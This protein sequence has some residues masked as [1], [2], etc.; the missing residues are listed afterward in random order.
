MLEKSIEGCWNVDG[1]RG[2]SD[3]W[4]GFARFTILD[5]KKPPDWMY[6]VRGATDKEVNDIQ[7]RLRVARDTERH[8]RSVEMKREAKMEQS[9]PFVN[10]SHF[11]SVCC[12]QNVSSASCPKKIAK[13]IQQVH[14]EERIVAQLKPTVNLVS[15]TGASLSTVQ[16][17]KC[18]QPSRDNQ[19]TW[20]E[21]FDSFRKDRETRSQGLK[22]K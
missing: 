21:R 7:A 6:M 11:C 17:P 14:G 3:M 2:L 1:D 10:I 4:T 9:F 15:K 5:G 12:S 16:S 18:I 22:S 20:S 13:R 8:V 19:N